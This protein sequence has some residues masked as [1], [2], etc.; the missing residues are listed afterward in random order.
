MRRPAAAKQL[1]PPSDALNLPEWYALQCVGDCMAPTL[2]DG[3]K[4][5]FHTK[6]PVKK[7][8]VV[9]VWFRPEVVRPGGHQA[10]VKRPALALR[11]GLTFPYREHPESTVA[12]IAM[13]SM[14]NRPHEWLPVPCADILAMHKYVGQKDS[15]GNFVDAG[16]AK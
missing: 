16:G 10:L 1:P 14:D 12:M 11:P 9:V 13:L 8:D 5:V 6:S 15:E 2:K 7:G 3:C 4:A